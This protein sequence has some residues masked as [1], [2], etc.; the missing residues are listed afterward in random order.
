MRLASR[1]IAVGL[2]T[3]VSFSPV[4]AAPQWFTAEVL[5][6]GIASNGSVTILLVDTAGAFEA[7]WFLSEATIRKELLATALTALSAD[8]TV[9]AFLDPD[10]PGTPDVFDLYARK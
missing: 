1:A 2:L 3:L 6:T 4:Q 9:F 10:A 5:A 7:K 8:L